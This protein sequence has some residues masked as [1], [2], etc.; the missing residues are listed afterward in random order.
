[1]TVYLTTIR[2]TRTGR[3]KATVQ[4]VAG[5]LVGQAIDENLAAAE[6]RARRQAVAWGKDRG[7]PT[8]IIKRREVK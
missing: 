3:Y 2:G 5:A 4:T 8:L 1:M 6:R 7:W